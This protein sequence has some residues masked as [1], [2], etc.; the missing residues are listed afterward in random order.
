MK[1]ISVL[2][3]AA[4]AA[5]RMGDTKQL[6]PFRNSTFLEHSILQAN[7][8]K[9]NQVF[10]VLGANSSIIRKNI[11]SKEL[12]FIDNKNWK[13][14]LST[15][16]VSGVKYIQC[17]IEQPDAILVMLAD[18]PLVDSNYINLLIDYFYKATDRIIASSYGNKNGVP[19]IFPK[20]TFEY[21]LQLYG[22]K[23]AKEILNSDVFKI[24][25]VKPQNINTLLD[26]DTPTD[27]KNLLNR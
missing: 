7:K 3:L 10:C 20:E 24:I 19:A 1:N 4:G 25:S 26:V 18:Q 23:G 12:T 22:D 2:I 16:I 8:S 11:N 5:S 15:S 13:E 14:G 6:L 21:L 9:A 27:Y 17:L